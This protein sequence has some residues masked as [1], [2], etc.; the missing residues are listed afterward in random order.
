[1]SPRLPSPLMAVQS[2]GR[3]AELVARGH[4]RAFEVLVRR[5]RA[6]LLRYCRRMGLSE[7]Q[8]E[9]VLQHSFTKAWL[10]LDRG[11]PV[12][13]VRPSIINCQG[14]K[15]FWDRQKYPPGSLGK[16]EPGVMSYY[17]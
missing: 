12:K 13:E 11:T 3:L 1:M 8:A 10:A 4:E 9:D 15:E 16:I 7:A 6:A 5:Y 14:K 17:H 2:D